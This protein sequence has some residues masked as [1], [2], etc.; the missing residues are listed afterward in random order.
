M[1]NVSQLPVDLRIG[2]N[3]INENM[4]LE[5]KKRLK[6]K[7]IIKIKFLDAFYYDKKNKRKEAIKQALMIINNLCNTETL[8]IIGNNAIIVKKKK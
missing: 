8:K 5:I 2:K 4:I 7:D 6:K 1:I 3:G